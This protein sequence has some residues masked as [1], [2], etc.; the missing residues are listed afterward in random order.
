LFKD[1]DVIWVD[2]REKLVLT[3]LQRNLNLDGEFHA[4]HGKV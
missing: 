1:T 2:C 3:A 4:R